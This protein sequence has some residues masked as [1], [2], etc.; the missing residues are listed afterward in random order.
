V[1]RQE[2]SERIWRALK[3][4]AENEQ[5]NVSHH[6]AIKRV[7]A[8]ARRE[9]TLEIPEP[10]LRFYADEYRDMVA[11]KLRGELQS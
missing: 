9:G 3:Q 1:R 10:A 8:V 4:L 6:E 7:K 5:S 11:R 2:P